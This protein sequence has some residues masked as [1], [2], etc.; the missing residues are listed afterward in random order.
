MSIFLDWEKKLDEETYKI[1]I[2]ID[3]GIFL[4]N[5]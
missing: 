3:D 5:T 2:V 1:G 4:D